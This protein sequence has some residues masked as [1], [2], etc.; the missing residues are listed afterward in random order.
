MSYNDN[1]PAGAEFDSSAPWNQ[2]DAVD[3]AIQ[4]LLP[5][6]RSD[7][8]NELPDLLWDIIKEHTS[9]EQLQDIL[10]DELM[11]T[12]KKLWES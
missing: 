1:L 11:W 4:Q 3:N 7:I 10:Y 9:D 2:T 5:D 8:A 6:V 12:A